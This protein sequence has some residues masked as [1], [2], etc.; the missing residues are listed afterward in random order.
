MRQPGRLRRSRCPSL[1]W[2]TAS[3]TSLASLNSRVSSRLA[4]S[5]SSGQTAYARWGL[6]KNSFGNMFKQLRRAFSSRQWT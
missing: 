3:A 6:V 2:E 5:W 4:R 1:K